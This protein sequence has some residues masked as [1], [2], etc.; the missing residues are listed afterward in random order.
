MVMV[1]LQREEILAISF[2]HTPVGYCQTAIANAWE[3]IPKRVL[4]AIRARWLPERGT[5][6]DVRSDDSLRGGVQAHGDELNKL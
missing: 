1:L 6:G 3:E 5:R 4:L 2:Y